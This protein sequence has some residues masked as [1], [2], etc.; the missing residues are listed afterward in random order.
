MTADY[1]DN[2]ITLTAVESGHAIVTVELSMNGSSLSKSYEIQITARHMQAGLTLIDS[3][4][5]QPENALESA[6]HPERE[7]SALPPLPR[8]IWNCRP[9]IRPRSCSPALMS[10]T[11]NPSLWKLR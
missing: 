2:A 5:I 7:N 4:A 11:A 6:F 10:P 8:V 1:A 3:R 9:A